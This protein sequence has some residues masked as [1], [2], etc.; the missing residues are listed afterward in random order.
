[1]VKIAALIQKKESSSKGLT[2]FD[3]EEIYNILEEE[4]T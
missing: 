4:K 3:K 1:L 2:K